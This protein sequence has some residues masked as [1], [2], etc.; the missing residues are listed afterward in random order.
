MQAQNGI[1]WIFV[2]VLAALSVGGCSQKSSLEGARVEP[3]TVDGRKFE[4][5]MTP[6]GTPDEY[7]MLIVR[8]TLVIN[9]DPELE[10][11]RAQGVAQRYMKQTCRGKTPKETLS[12][13][14]NNV[15]YRVVFRCV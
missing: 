10:T 13:L 3:I 2:T 6:T 8:A 9:A 1:A 4:V 12:G 11:A 15:N 7:R 14:E 5:R